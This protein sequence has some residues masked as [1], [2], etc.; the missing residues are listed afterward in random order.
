MDMDRQPPEPASSP[1]RGDTAK[2]KCHR[3][4]DI[5]HNPPGS[6]DI[7]HRRL[8]F[9]KGH[10][11]TAAAAGHARADLRDSGCAIHPSSSRFL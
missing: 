9:L 1:A 4:R 3:N 6:V 7:L 10:R 8:D 2:H 5:S 11:R